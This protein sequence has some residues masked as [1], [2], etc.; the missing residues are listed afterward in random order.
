[1]TM[2][3]FIRLC[4]L[5][6][7]VRAAVAFV[8]L[9]LTCRTFKTNYLFAWALWASY[10]VVIIF[11]IICCFCSGGRRHKP[12]WVLFLIPF[13]RSDSCALFWCRRAYKKGSTV[14]AIDF[15]FSFH[16]LKCAKRHEIWTSV[17]EEIIREFIETI[18]NHVA[19]ITSINWQYSCRI[20]MNIFFTIYAIS[21][22]WVVQIALS[23]SL[24]RAR[25]RFGPTFFHSTFV[26]K[27]IINGRYSMSLFN[28]EKTDKNKYFER[29]SCRHRRRCWHLSHRNYNK[30]EA[31]HKPKR[32]NRINFNPKSWLLKIINF[33]I[34]TAIPFVFV[35]RVHLS[36][37]AVSFF[38]RIIGTFRFF[39]HFAA[40]KLIY[41]FSIH[42]WFFAI[43]K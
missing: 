40:C 42:L 12:I 1:M 22:R 34:S 36:A 18:R 4:F 35:Q 10:F 30:Y 11:A 38:D 14:K 5:H 13:R 43:Q 39:V 7:T 23:L 31:T 16:R 8:F 41:L 32:K 21:L 27:I 15:S 9:Q 28:C 33:M 6:A 17:S 29:F 25:R 19:Q 3:A 26:Q 24:P 2:V 37:F 20:K